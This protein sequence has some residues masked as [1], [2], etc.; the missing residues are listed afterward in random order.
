MIGLNELISVLPSLTQFKY[1][2]NLL[3]VHGAWNY[4]RV[5]KCI[6]YCFYKNIVLYIIEVRKS[7]HCNDLLNSWDAQNGWQS[8]K[9]LS[10]YPLMSFSRRLNYHSLI[11]LTGIACM[12]PSCCRNA[13]LSMWSPQAI[14]MWWYLTFS[15]PGADSRFR[16]LT[17]QVKGLLSAPALSW[18]AFGRFDLQHAWFRR[19]YTSGTSFRFPQELKEEIVA[20]LWSESYIKPL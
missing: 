20:D 10:H 5:S 8:T 17:W 14:H 3:L 12:S 4:N 16:D 7:T 6:L 1:L 18:G 2:K 13:G 9:N 15:R 19:P 11:K